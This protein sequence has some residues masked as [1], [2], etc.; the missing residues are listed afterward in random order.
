MDVLCVFWEL[1]TLSAVEI[2][3]LSVQITYISCDKILYIP[4]FEWV[5]TNLLLCGSVWTE[6]D[7]FFESDR[8]RGD[9]PVKSSFTP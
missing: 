7:I 8:L 3:L 9:G 6:A 5:I 1:D 4:Q 2:S